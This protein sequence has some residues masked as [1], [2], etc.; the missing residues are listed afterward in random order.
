VTIRSDSKLDVAKFTTLNRRNLL[1]GLVAGSGLIFTEQLIRS[2][3]AAPVFH[4]DPF[5]LGL[6]SGD[7]SAFGVVL[8]TKI[9]PEPLTQGGGMP[10]QPIEVDWEVASDER[11][12]DIVA[13]GTEIA[14]PEL[15]HSVHAE[16]EGL[17]PARDYFYRFK[18]GAERS[19]IGRTRTMPGP[20]M[21]N[22]V[23]FGVIGC[24]RY[25]HG[26]WGAYNDVAEAKPDFVYHYGDYIY[27]GRAVKRTSAALGRYVRELP[28]LPQECYSLADYRLRYAIYKSDPKLQRAHLATPFIHSFDDHEVANDW[29][30]DVDVKGAPKDIF[31]L[32]RAAAMQAWY[33]NLA[34]RRTSLPRGPDVQMFRRFEIGDLIRFNVLDT[35][36]YRTGLVCKGK[37]TD[38]CPDGINEDHTMLGERQEA[39]LNDGFKSAAKPW[40]VLGQQI[41]MAEIHA[42]T[43]PDKWDRAPAARKRLFDAIEQSRTANV[44]ALTGD[45]HYGAAAELKRNFSDIKSATLGIE[46]VGNSVSSHTAAINSGAWGEKTRQALPYVKH[47]DTRKGWTQHQVSKT[48][49]TAEFRI[50]NDPTDD[51]AKLETGKRMMVEAGSQ[52]LADA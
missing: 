7:P 6:A 42:E 45:V 23:R 9:A 5:S 15:A 18:V 27:E 46:F 26:F 49:W 21:M 8:W 12:R 35:R 4:N 2:A 10:G 30:S 33:E 28:G 34:V 14:R 52:R 20:G 22:E 36:Q 24:Q 37:T 3:V 11:M 17:L 25:E 50:Q 51:N 39:W 1:K 13:K 38:K 31:L 44:I 29:T 41:L 47:V 43:K 40:T 19:V 48:T 32:R 16:V